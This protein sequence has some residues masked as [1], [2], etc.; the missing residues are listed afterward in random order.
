MQNLSYHF[1]PETGNLNWRKD[2]NNP[3]LPGDDLIETFGYDDDKL[4]TRLTSWAVEGQQSYSIQFMDNGNVEEKTD[5]GIYRYNVV[6]STGDPHAVSKIENPS[7]DYLQ[8]APPQN[9]TYTPFDK[10]N[11]IKQSTTNRL[12]AFT[13]GPLNHRKVSKLYYTNEADGNTLL[14]TKYFVGG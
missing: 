12:M 14:R 3:A 5:V 6:G 7:D 4:K 10:V 2:L 13:Y 11:T 8:N 9:V 1:N